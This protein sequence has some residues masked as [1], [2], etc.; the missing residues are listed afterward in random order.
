MKKIVG[1]KRYNTETAEELIAWGNQ[2]YRSDPRWCRE[3]LYRTLK[4]AFFIHGEGGS[5]SPYFTPSENNKN[6][7]GET[8]LP[9]NEVEAMEWMEKKGMEDDIELY[10]DDVIED[11]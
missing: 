10:F 4:G 3:T 2:Y 1:G 6:G 7:D 11:A 5:M 8:I 9:V